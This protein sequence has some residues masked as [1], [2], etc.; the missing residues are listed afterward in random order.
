[1][2]RRYTKTNRKLWLHMLHK[3]LSDCEA[4]FTFIALSQ[5]ITRLK[6]RK[7]KKSQKFLSFFELSFFCK[8]K[9]D[10][11]YY[12]KLK[13]ILTFFSF[14]NWIIYGKLVKFK[15][16][17]FSS[18]SSFFTSC[19]SFLR[20]VLRFF[21]F[22]EFFECYWSLGQNTTWTRKN[23]LIIL[24]FEFGY[25]TQT[26]NKFEFE[27]WTQNS[28]STQNFKLKTCIGLYCIHARQHWKAQW[29]TKA[30]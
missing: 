13:I 21:E 24:S 11:K 18:V 9:L 30:Q 15:K 12:S 5:C 14:I 1:M 8:L 20:V 23:L 6:N 2:F 29:N 7:L 16:V 17:T 22:F 28:N 10:S 19:L 4:D 27:L 3:K 25:Q 26:Q